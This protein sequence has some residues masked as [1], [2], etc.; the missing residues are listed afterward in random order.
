MAKFQSA[1]FE[2]ISEGQSLPIY[3][4]PDADDLQDR[5]TRQ[6][7]VEAVT[8]ATF[9]VKVTLDPSFDLT[10]C[11]AVRMSVRFDNSG[12]NFIADISHEDA[13]LGIRRD[14]RRDSESRYN[15]KT[16]QWETAMFTFGKLDISELYH[17]AT[18]KNY[19]AYGY[20][21]EESTE[22]AISPE[23]LKG[24]GMIRISYRRIRYGRSYDNSASYSRGHARVSEVS[25][26]TLKGQSIENTIDMTKVSASRKPQA[27]IEPIPVLGR[28]GQEVTMNIMYRS[29]RTLEM[30]GCIPSTTRQSS[31]T[32]AAARSPTAATLDV[33][34]EMRALR[35]RL[36]ELEN[37]AN[38][39]DVK[40][41]PEKRR[42][43]AI[44]KP[45]NEDQENTGQRKRRRR[46]GPVETVDLTG[47]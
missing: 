31:T 24:L 36:A 2:I 32:Q 13:R 30:I 22:S 12:Y 27:Y 35:A 17:R 11:D 41:K 40:I 16:G 3:D 42:A 21:E 10:G 5:F 20:S 45:E 29:R 38:H 43:T 18:A 39:N 26:K 9:E 4:D 19:L 44:V 34:G 14:A 1:T 28:L 8:G 25:E 15:S 47:D 7:Y 46:S 37:N 33:Q 6:K 23:V